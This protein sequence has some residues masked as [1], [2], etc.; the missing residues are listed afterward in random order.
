MLHA[1]SLEIVLPGET[2]PRKFTAAIPPQMRAV[3]KKI[4][5]LSPR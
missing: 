3:L 2:G 1:R 4:Q 5:S